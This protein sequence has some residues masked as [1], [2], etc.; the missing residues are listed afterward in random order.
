MGARKLKHLA[1]LFFT[2]LT[3]CGGAGIVSKSFTYGTGS[4]E[5]LVVYYE[6]MGRTAAFRAADLKSEAFV[7][8][9]ELIQGHNP[10][11]GSQL[12][13]ES[14]EGDDRNWTVTI[15]RPEGERLYFG[16][17]SFGFYTKSFEHDT[18][19]HTANFNDGPQNWQC[20]SEKAEVYKLEPGK[21]NLIIGAR[22]HDVSQAP[23][24][25]EKSA[26]EIME[27]LSELNKNDALRDEY[28]AVE[29]DANIVANLKQVLEGYPNIQGEIKIAQPLGEVTFKGSS[30]NLF[31]LSC[32]SNGTKDFTIVSQY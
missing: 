5:Y 25:H 11:F 16:Y 28:L 24:L 32:P 31:G 29:T 23:G 26:L 19:V 20:H 7:D 18:I 1:L 17:Q 21:I 27:Y 13:N 15:L 12:K 30:N 14:L 2:T 22:L 9:A 10:I 6:P 8:K 4:S 3:A